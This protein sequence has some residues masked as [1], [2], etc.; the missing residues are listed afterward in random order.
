MEAKK[1]PLQSLGSLTLEQA[2]HHLTQGFYTIDNMEPIDPRLMPGEFVILHTPTQ[3]LRIQS[4]PYSWRLEMRDNNPNLYHRFCQLITHSYQ[5]SSHQHYPL[6]TPYDTQ[7]IRANINISPYVVWPHDDSVFVDVT[8]REERT[9]NI[10]MCFLNAVPLARQKEVAGF[11]GKL[12]SDRGEL[13]GWLR[14]LTTF[15]K[16]DGTEYSKRVINIVETAQKFAKSNKDR[17]NTF[18][19]NGRMVT[20]NKM[21]DDNIRNLVMKEEGG[22]LYRLVKEMNEKKNN[23]KE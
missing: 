2:N 19:R 3:L 16:L 1:P 10:W 4:T 11:L 23:P 15:N 6:V 18:D 14:S 20:L 5:E 12:Y 17:G 9:K 8:D 22:S 7:S 13:I 21:V